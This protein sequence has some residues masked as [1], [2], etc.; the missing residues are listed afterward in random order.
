MEHKQG[1]PTRFEDVQEVVKDFY[2]DKLRDSLCA[3]LRPYARIVI[4]PQAKP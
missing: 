1:Q 3:K 2:C 4:T